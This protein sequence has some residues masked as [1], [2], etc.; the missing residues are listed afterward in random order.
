MLK[1]RMCVYTSKT[2]RMDYY[3]EKEPSLRYKNKSEKVDILCHIR[4]RTLFLDYDVP[5][6]KWVL[7]W[8]YPY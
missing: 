1:K 6:S 8:L 4:Q 3:L 2:R 5:Q 7:K